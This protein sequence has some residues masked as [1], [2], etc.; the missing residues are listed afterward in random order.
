MEPRGAVGEDDLTVAIES[1][2]M[3]LNLGEL[4]ILAELGA[5]K[6]LAALLEHHKDG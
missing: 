3:R 6:A 2:N 5:S 4:G 1:R